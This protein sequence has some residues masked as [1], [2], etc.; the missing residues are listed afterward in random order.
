MGEKEFSVGSPFLVVVSIA[1]NVGEVVLQCSREAERVPSK[2][3]VRRS[4]DNVQILGQGSLI[5]VGADGL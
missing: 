4:L 3:A 2:W 5:Y 1:S